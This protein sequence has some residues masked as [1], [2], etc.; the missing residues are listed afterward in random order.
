[1]LKIRYYIGVVFITVYS[2]I[3]CNINAYTVYI[4]PNVNY[5]V[6]KD[7]NLIGANLS[8]YGQIF[9][10][11]IYVGFTVGYNLVSIKDNVSL[12]DYFDYKDENLKASLVKLNTVPLIFSIK[13]KYMLNNNINL[14]L[15]PFFGF[16]NGDQEYYKTKNDTQQSLTKAIV[17]ARSIYGL[18]L[19]TIYK[20]VGVS[21]GYRYLTIN[22][23]YYMNISNSTSLESIE[24]V[25]NKTLNNHG[26]SLSLFYW[27][28]YTSSK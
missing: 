19:G 1:M 17:N 21:V 3:I 22:N 2:F 4:A 6:S 5:G 23:S 18:N 7:T 26:L 9:T 24:I 15:E 11:N 20:N 12:L 25:K 28:S 27:F 16:L 13:Y 14:T 8:A 10:E